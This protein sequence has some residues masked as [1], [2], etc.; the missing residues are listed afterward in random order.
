MIPFLL[1]LFAVPTKKSLAEHNVL[2]KFVDLLAVLAVIN[3]LVGTWQY[4]DHPTDDSF[5][6]IYSRYSLSLYGLMALNIVLF[7]WYFSLF[8][9]YR[10]KTN[11]VISLGF[12]LAAVMGFYGA[13]LAAFVCAFV[14]SFFR[15]RLI[16]AIRVLLISVVTVFILYYLTR[17]LRPEALN[18]YE[19]SAGRL[20]EFNKKTSPRKILSFYNYATAYPSDAKDFLFGSG[21]GT[22]NSR[23]AF[24]AG[25]PYYFTKFSFLKSAEQPFYFKNYIF[26]LW[27]NT[28]TSQ[29]LLQDGFRNQP[30]SSLLA[31]LGEYGLIFFLL[32]GFAVFQYFKRV[33]NTGGKFNPSLCGL[34]WIFRFLLIFLFSLLFIDNYLEYPEVILLITVLMKLVHIEIAKQAAGNVIAEQSM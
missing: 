2:N 15:F 33:N 3:D 13:G 34:H 7:G 18:Y 27:N 32:F 5:I 23:S 31:F 21:P 22:F 10:K 9:Q 25:S 28:N 17:W 30:F 29:L 8:L 16:A 19:V 11:L 14:V 20:M 26:P 6:G 12:L 1:L 24:M 4:I